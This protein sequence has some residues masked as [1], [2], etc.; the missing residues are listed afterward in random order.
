MLKARKGNLTAASS[1]L[2]LGSACRP[3]CAVKDKCN[4]HSGNGVLR[5]SKFSR[6]VTAMMLLSFVSGYART[7]LLRFHVPNEAKHAHDPNSIPI[8]I[9]FVPCHAVTG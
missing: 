3:F 8:R 1:I 6:Q 5:T 7:E 9:K 4:P 2:P